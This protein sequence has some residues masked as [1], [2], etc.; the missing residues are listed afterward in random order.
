MVA[1]I[2]DAAAAYASAA[3]SAIEPGLE[4]R[5]TGN[6][7]AFGDLVRAGLDGAIEAGRAGDQAAIQ[8]LTGAAD[9]NDVVLAV[10]NAELTLQTVVG[11]RDRVIQ[12]YQEIIR[13][14]V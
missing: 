7:N 11:I 3:G 4:A 12:A 5:D 8:G 10:S 2:S 1:R 14:P 6:A 9:V 13:M